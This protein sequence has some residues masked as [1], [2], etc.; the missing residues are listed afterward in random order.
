MKGGIYQIEIQVNGKRYIGSTVNFRKRW[1]E[2]LSAFC[3]RKHRNPHLQAAFE[4]YGG[5]VFVFTILEGVRDTSQLISREQY[6][7]DT[8][9]PEYNIALVAGMPMLGRH[10]TAEAKRKISEGNKG[11]TFTEGH[12]KRLRETHKARRLIK[13]GYRKISEAMKGKHPSEE[14]R[15][16]MSEAGKGRRFSTEHRQ[17]ISQA[18]KGKRLSKEHRRKLSEAAKAYW[19]RVRAGK[20]HEEAA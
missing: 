18:M 7:L 13:G 1:Q 6:Y 3:H 17:R 12:R 8:L 19:Y 4:K 2:H 14:T 9:N 10:H 16:R 20:N 15:R 5:E 11:R